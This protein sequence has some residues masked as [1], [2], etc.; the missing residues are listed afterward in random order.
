MLWSASDDNEFISHILGRD[1]D[2]IEFG[3]LPTLSFLGYA[4][5]CHCTI[6]KWLDEDCEFPI[7]N[8]T[9]GLKTIFSV[10]YPA[11][12]SC[13]YCERGWHMFHSVKHKHA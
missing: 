7:G 10:S 4:M 9:C 3:G 2:D 8:N 5:I 13:Y 1:R 11:S 6:L 12:R